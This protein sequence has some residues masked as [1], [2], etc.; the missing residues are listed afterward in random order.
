MK[1]LT[2]K[3]HLFFFGGIPVFLLLG[4]LKKDI[5][6][7]IEISYINYLLNVDFWCYVSAIYFG[8]IGVNYL[9]LDWANK[10]P[11]KLLTILHIL[12]QTLAL[13]PYL[14]A[15]LHLDSQGVL[16]QKE[17]LG[18]NLNALFLMAI[19]LFLGSIVLHL[20]NFLI[21]FFL[22]TE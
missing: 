5:P 2:K 19:L 14:Y 8:L 18:F 13:I 16:E 20:T 7:A 22:K 1:L 21:S 4:F 3:P 6:I 11:K 10:T 9:A 12:L 17:L 15:I